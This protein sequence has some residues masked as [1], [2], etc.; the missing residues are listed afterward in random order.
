MK[1][2]SEI[3]EILKDNDIGR[4]DLFWDMDSYGLKEGLS[5]SDYAQEG[6]KNVM[7]TFGTEVEV[8]HEDRIGTDKDTK[9]IVWHFKDPDVYIKMTGWYSSWEGTM[10]D[11]DTLKEV[12]PT[13]KT[14]TVYNEIEDVPEDNSSYDSY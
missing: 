14:I 5:D 6:H 9:V 3:I 2:A 11:E 8:V 7:D 12:Y 13:T 4:G 1:D 10:W